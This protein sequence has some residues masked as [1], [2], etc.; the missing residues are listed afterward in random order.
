MNVITPVFFFP[1]PLFLSEKAELVSLALSTPEVV[2]HVILLAI[3]HTVFH[4]IVANVIF[5]F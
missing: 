3:G 2:M 1:F 4:L 5:S